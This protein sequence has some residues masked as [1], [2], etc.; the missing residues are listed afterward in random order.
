MTRSGLTKGHEIPK[1]PMINLSV[2]GLCWQD[3]LGWWAGWS[4]QEAP[5]ATWVKRMGGYIP[6]FK[7]IFVK[8]AN[9]F[10]CEKLDNCVN[11]KSAI[12]K[13][14][15]YIPMHVMPIDPTSSSLILEEW[16]G[17]E[18]FGAISCFAEASLP[19]SPIDSWWF[20]G[21]IVRVLNKHVLGGELEKTITNKDQ[22][23]W[24]FNLGY[25]LLHPFVQNKNPKQLHA[26]LM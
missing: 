15:L 8:S 1:P 10:K 20:L 19:S 25:F 23:T 2:A 24:L 6:I 11:W 7:G 9:N 14:F 22:S 21:W 12:S 5:T 13:P 17:Q 16:W 4:S 26:P 3:C 18:R